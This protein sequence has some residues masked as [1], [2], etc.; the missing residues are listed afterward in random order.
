MPTTPRTVLALDFGSKRIGLAVAS[1]AARLPQPL[2][3]LEW[4]DKFFDRLAEIINRENVETL[5]V[6][7]PRGLQGQQTA[8]TDSAESFARELRGR[9]GLPVDLQDE[10]LT[11]TQAEAELQARGR[12]YKPAE[13]DALAAV[14]I[15]QDYL[16]DQSETAS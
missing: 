4:N 12:P 7:R 15:L 14:Y 3:T 6:G 13:I 2:S 9:F 11:S 8:Q 1:L 5:V 16:N 10:A